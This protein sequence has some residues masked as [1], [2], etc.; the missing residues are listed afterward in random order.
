MLDALGDEYIAQHIEQA[1]RDYLEETSYR[2][3]MSNVSSSIM[4]MISGS[5]PETRWS[6]LLNDLD[7][8]VS[9]SPAQTETEPEIRNRILTKLK[10]KEDS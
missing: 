8:A 7:E 10:G 2:I 4:S 6:D 1:Y 5:E 9:Y 3:Y